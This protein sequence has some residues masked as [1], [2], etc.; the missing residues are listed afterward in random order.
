MIHWNKSARIEFRYGKDIDNLIFINALFLSI[1]FRK[2]HK[3]YYLKNKSNQYKK[4]N[5]LSFYLG[6][7]NLVNTAR[8]GLT[9]AVKFLL[10][11]GADV[12]DEDN[13]G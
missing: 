8:N 2:R 4:N 13:N 7:Y 12:N 1:C 11:D 10:E 3:K 5:T 6:N 9:D